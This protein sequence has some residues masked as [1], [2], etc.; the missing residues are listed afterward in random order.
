LSAYTTCETFYGIVAVS[1][2]IVGVLL[3][4]YYFRNI[5]DKFIQEGL[6]V[7]SLWFAVN[8]LPDLIVLVGMFKTPLVEYFISPGLMYLTMPPI[9]TGVGYILSKK[10]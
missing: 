5:T 7:G 2:T 3:L 8:I 4:A 6:L 10:K 1:G 9:S